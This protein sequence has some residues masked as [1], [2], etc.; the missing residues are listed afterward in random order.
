[1]IGA[2]AGCVVFLWKHDI[3][4]S[5]VFSATLMFTMTAASIVG[6]VI[7][8]T[9]NKIKLDP[10]ITSSAFMTATLLIIDRIK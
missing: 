8:L 10:A 2:C 6:T 1:M 4:L 7:P 9:L 5:L 3:I